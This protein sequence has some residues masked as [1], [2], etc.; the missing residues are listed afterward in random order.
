MI[1]KKEYSSM[2]I[3]QEKEYSSMHI[4]QEKD[5]MIDME[6]EKG[7]IKKG[8]VRKEIERIERQDNSS[9]MEAIRKK[10]DMID[11]EREKGIIMKEIE[12]E[13]QKDNLIDLVNKKW[14]HN[15]PKENDRL[16][17]EIDKKLKSIERSMTETQ[18]NSL[19]KLT[20]KTETLNS[21]LERR[22]INNGIERGITVLDIAKSSDNERIDRNSRY[23]ICY[24]CKDYG[25]TKKQCE[26][27]NKIVKRINKL[28]FEKD[29]INELMEIFNVK[30]KEIDQI[31]KELKSTNPHKINKRKEKQKKIIMKLIE[32]LLN[33]LK[34]KKDYLLK[35][36]DSID[37]LVVCFKCKGYGHHAK[38]C[39]KKEKVKKERTK[40]K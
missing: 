38:E 2:H 20:K 40:M 18:D 30:Q 13:R 5:D 4:V 35:L 25:H 37:I 1:E 7:I 29:I 23:T 24:K 8:I 14:R 32:N 34:D 33:H 21:P 12:K 16:K 17:K 6:R 28:D 9:S 3:V 39:G 15:S 27:H 36:K 22:N 26:R 11:I 19:T 31:K 10:L